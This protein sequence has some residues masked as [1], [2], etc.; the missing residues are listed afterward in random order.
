ML[1]TDY[2][3]QARAHSGLSSDNRLSAALEISQASVSLWRRGLATAEAE[4]AAI[5][6]EREAAERQERAARLA[7]AIRQRRSAAAAR[8]ARIA[9]AIIEAAPLRQVAAQCGVSLRTVERARARLVA[10]IR[11]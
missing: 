5:E 1:L 8:Q 11:P 6:R 7:A 9:G 10:T 2:L 4:R 3:D